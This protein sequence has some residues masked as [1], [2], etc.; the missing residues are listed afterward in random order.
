MRR[1]VGLSA[2]CLS[3]FHAASPVQAET[4]AQRVGQAAE[5][6]VNALR[7]EHGRSALRADEELAE[8]AANHASD[9]AKNDFFSHEGSDGSDVAERVRAAG[10]S[11]CW[12]GENLAE[13]TG[14]VERTLD[15]WMASRGHRQ[16]LLSPE[17]AE[18]ALVRAEDD[19]WVMV[20][21]RPGC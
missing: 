2:L 18:F 10:Y 17:A 6:A 8:A 16:N 12:V 19:L 3:V 15:L 7:A 14:D 9:M 20:L 5:A 4:L 11:Y 1:I 21:A 13:G